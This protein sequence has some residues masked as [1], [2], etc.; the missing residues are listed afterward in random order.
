MNTE[1]LN[2]LNK[3]HRACELLHIEFNA[4]LGHAGWYVDVPHLRAIIYDA[5]LR[6]DSHSG[7]CLEGVAWTD[8][9]REEF[10]DTITYRYRDWAHAL[11]VDLMSDEWEMCF[12]PRGLIEDP[13]A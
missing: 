8:G 5:E 4:V 3:L 11:R 6:D 9:I 13:P 2:T 7:V 1:E 12:E 10:Y